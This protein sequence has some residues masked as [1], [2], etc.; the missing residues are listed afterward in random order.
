MPRIKNQ[1]KPNQKPQQDLEDV[2]YPHD[3]NARGDAHTIQCIG[4]V[5]SGPMLGSGRKKKLSGSSP[6]GMWE[7]VKL[8]ILSPGD[9]LGNF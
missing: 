5:L 2:C 6:W 1:T 7:I 9:P 4:F 8:L 3:P